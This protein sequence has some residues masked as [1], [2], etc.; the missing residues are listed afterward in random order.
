M[1]STSTP[2]NALPCKERTILL[3]RGLKVAAKQWGEE[4]EH[5]HRVL[6]IHGW[7][8]S[9]SSWD[10][11]IPLLPHTNTV[12]VAI[13]LP[14]HGYSDHL[15]SDARYSIG[16]WVTRMVDV[17]GALQWQWCSVVAHS[18][19]AVIAAVVRIKQEA[20]VHRHPASLS[21]RTPCYFLCLHVSYVA[22]PSLP[23]RSLPLH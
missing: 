14:S 19:G 9:S 1:S 2:T 23:S 22:H 3:P 11:L 13:D 17:I 21:V 5:A 8:D 6:C 7:L 12:Y 15:T 18:M 10:H 4:N 20:W 16:H